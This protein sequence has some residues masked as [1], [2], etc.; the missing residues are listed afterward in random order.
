MR[1]M[2]SVLKAGADR[3]NAKAGADKSHARDECASPQ[4]NET[5]LIPMT[6]HEEIAARDLT[7]RTMFLVL[8]SKIVLMIK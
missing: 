7:A 8:L 5:E 6:P 4:H 3:R 1:S 2:I